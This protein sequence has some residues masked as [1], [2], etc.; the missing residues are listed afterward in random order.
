MKDEYD[1]LIENKMC[2]LVPRPSNT[3]IIRSLWIFR[4]KKYSDGLFE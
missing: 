1:D 4:H 3:N 2:D